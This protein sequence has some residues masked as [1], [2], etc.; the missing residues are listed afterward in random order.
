MNDQL[1]D[2]TNLADPGNPADR[3]RLH[4]R[5]RRGEIDLAPAWHTPAIIGESIDAVLA[6]LESLRKQVANGGAA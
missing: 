5:W 4:N 1:I 6:E 3:L 2:A